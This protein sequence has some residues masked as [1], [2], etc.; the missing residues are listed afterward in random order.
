L[1]WVVFVFFLSLGFQDSVI[2][3]LRT[4]KK[5]KKKKEHGSV[6]VL[7][8]VVMIVVVMLYRTVCFCRGC[9]IGT[10]LSSDGC[11]AIFYVLNCSENNLGTFVL[12]V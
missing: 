8:I 7:V 9:C 5:K 6:L 3:L 4:V 12:V 1:H 11:A 2:G 10:E